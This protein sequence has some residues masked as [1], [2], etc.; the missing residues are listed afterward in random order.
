MLINNKIDTCTLSVPNPFEENK[1]IDLSIRKEKNSKIKV[2]YIDSKPRISVNLYLEAH[3]L[4]LNKTVDYTSLETMQKLEISSEQYLKEKLE[5]FLYKTS[6]EFNSDICGFGK[7]ALSK[8]LTW[9]E[10]QNS[11]WL[12]NYRASFFDVNVNLTLISG[13][14]F[15]KSP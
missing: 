10:W 13:S 15:D 2:D 14:E 11:N 7:H 4:T 12:D 5:N 8:Y 3:G 6:K 1:V 9:D